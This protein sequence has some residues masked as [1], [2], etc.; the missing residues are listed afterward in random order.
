MGRAPRA[1][2][3]T[4]VRLPEALTAVAVLLCYLTRHACIMMAALNRRAGHWLHE[5]F[6]RLLRLH[7]CSLPAQILP[8]G[9]SRSRPQGSHACVHEFLI[10]R[11]RHSTSFLS[12]RRPCL[13]S[14]KYEHLKYM[15]SYF[16]RALNF[17][18]AWE[19]HSRLATQSAIAGVLAKVPRSRTCGCLWSPGTPIFRP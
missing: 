9:T 6:P 5:S 7:R 1:S 10:H 17:V 2:N 15:Y 18:D 12:S 3:R 4:S 11:S 19:L 16:L 14:S 8:R 13:A